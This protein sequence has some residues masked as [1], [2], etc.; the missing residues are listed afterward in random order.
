MSSGK[1]GGGRART[2]YEAPNTLHSKQVLRLIDAISEGEV[3]G[4]VHGDEYPFK[5]IYFNDTPVQNSDGSFN[6]T[7]IKA[8]ATQGTPDQPYL[9]GFDSTQKT[10]AVSTEVK[11]ATAI[12]RSITDALVNRL[13]VTVGVQSLMAQKDNGDRVPTNIAMR[14]ELIAKGIVTHLQDWSL[15]EKGNAPFYQDLVFEQLPEVPFNLRVTRLTPDSLDDTTKNKSFFASYVEIIDAKLAYPNTAMVGLEIDSAQFGNQIPRRNY[16]L[17]GIKVQVPSNY[18]PLNRTY[19][20]GVWDGSF[21]FA[22]T[23]NP[24]WVYYDLITHDRYG[25][26]ER[27]KGFQADR[28]A[29][30][31]VAKFCDEL[32]DDGYGGKEPRVTFNAYITDQRSAYEV[33]SDLA[34]AFF[35]LSVWDGRLFRTTLDGPT[36]PV[37]SYSNANVKDG[38]FNYDFVARKAMINAV[39]VQYVDAKDGY[40]TRIEYVSDDVMIQRYGL[41]MQRVIRFGCTSRGEAVRYGLWIIETARRESEMVSFTVGAEGLRHVPFDIIEVAD[42]DYAGANISG[43]VVAVLG[44]VVTLDRPV[45]HVVDGLF[46]HVNER[47]QVVAWVITD[48]PRPDQLTLDVTEL[49]LQVGDVYTLTRK[50]VQPK[51]FRAIGI[52]ENGDGSYTINAI[53]HAAEKMAVVADGL[54]FEKEPYTL[55]NDVPELHN[56]T[57]GNDGE[58]VVLTWDNLTTLSGVLTYEV[59]L[60]R[61]GKIYKTWL[62]LYEPIFRFEGLPPGNYVAEVRAKN[63]RG[64]YSNVLTKAF[65]LNYEVTSLR[66]APKIFAIGLSWKLP[67]ILNEVVYSEVW[68]GTT[69]DLNQAR[70]LVSLPRPLNEHQLDNLDLNQ[71]YYF[72]VRL[73]NQSDMTGSFTE[74]VYGEPDQSGDKIVAHLSGKIT[75]TELGE[76]LLAQVSIGEAA[77][78]E[79]KQALSQ[80][81]QEVNDRINAVKQETAARVAQIKAE[82]TARLADIQH[83]NDGLTTEVSQRQ[84]AD[85]NIQSQVTT[86]KSSAADN[87][88]AIQSEQTARTNADRTLARRIDTVVATAGANKASITAEVTARADADRALGQR[89]DVVT[90]EVKG[91]TASI[92]RVEKAVAGAEQALVEVG[93]VLSAGFNS[94]TGNTKNGRDFEAQWIAWAGSPKGIAKV[95]G[96]NFVVGDR[97]ATVH[98]QWVGYTKQ[99]FPLIKGIAYKIS[100][101]ITQA[102]NPENSSTINGYNGIKSDGKTVVNSTG[103]NSLGSQHYF[104]TQ[105]IPQG[106]RRQWYGIAIHKDDWAAFKDTLPAGQMKVAHKDVAYI[107]PCLWLNYSGKRGV[108]L[109]H[110]VTIEV[111]DVS[112]M[113]I[114]D[115]IQADLTSFKQAQAN[116]DEATTQQ[117]NAALS[118]VGV[119]KTA[120]ATEVSTRA[121]ADSALGRRIDIVTATANRNTASIG[122]LETVVANNQT[123]MTEQ[124]NTASSTWQKAITIQ[125]TRNDNQ[126]PSWYYQNHPQRVV[127]E[128]KAAKAIGLTN[129]SGYADLETIVSWRDNSAGDIVQT[130]VWNGATK[131]RF[132]GAKGKPDVWSEWTTDL[133]KLVIGGRNYAQD[134]EFKQGMWSFTKQAAANNARGEI[135]DGWMQLYNL[136]GAGW[137]QWQLST[138]KATVLNMMAP[139]TEYTLSWE[140]RIVGNYPDSNVTASVLIR[141]ALA[142]GSS[143]DF[144]T[145]NYVLTPEIR[146]YTNTFTSGTMV[147]T[148][149]RRIMFTYNSRKGAIEIRRIKLEQGNVATDWAP[150]PE[151]VQDSIGAVSAEL[152]A[153]KQTQASSDTAMTRRL[154]TAES[155]VG[156][157]TANITHQSQTLATLSGQ[158]SA[159]WSVNVQTMA[160]GKQAVVGLALGVDG[161]TGESQFIVRADKFAIYDNGVK[162]L[163]V[164]V[165]GRAGLSGD[166]IVENT[167]LGKH[168]KA[169]ETIESPKIIGGSINIASGKFKVTNSGSVEIRAD[170]TKNVGLKITN[171]A[172][173]VYDEK[174]IDRVTLGD[175]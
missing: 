86:L 165:N 77:S 116:K 162:P 102:F 90:A 70:L 124:L 103:A 16:L 159:Q 17:R 152:V 84:Q 89:V 167:I 29:L 58:G 172:V 115:A 131:Y 110:Q 82:T 33:L 147:N 27:L 123:T 88:A 105:Q 23:N 119:N 75:G 5:S 101:D 145:Q 18:D 140:A 61:D 4:F 93:E 6:F 92:G 8:V 21:K 142:S 114:V 7:G 133:D 49:A 45:E 54:Y 98:Q 94:I 10:V 153:F 144:G 24:A 20:D 87:L 118:Q 174:G 62:D 135:R 36:D 107:A 134:T 175:F 57:I 136:D 129:D 65:S 154:E 1:K 3:D 73:N 109:V 44:N 138:A 143:Q 97:S 80:I 148:T 122:G 164:L 150:A 161:Q 56:G 32:V 127:N 69:D 66:A 95:E 121:S 15:N 141:C 83:L 9:A 42:N 111:I 35:G 130:A 85:E 11:Q 126:P 12:T 132:G 125:D 96:E 14:V 67:D 120:I 168:I 50:D 128:F 139:K 74:A 43:R 40:R 173:I 38:E 156:N 34:A 31:Q 163:F 53:K 108:V 171:Q 63:L 100:Y 19:A 157:N 81:A 112:R 160:N 2:P 104:A 55:W 151:D 25:L 39:Q 137:A 13:R 26:G 28:F 46:S 22:W 149:L 169:G 99:A 52:L 60:Y 91:N 146:R 76:D 79:A 71:G 106:E 30:Y 166:L 117:I 72:W 59:K 51:L 155:K 64:Q 158:I 47:M 48:Q 41:N 113:M 68:Y 37:C 170:A 78:L